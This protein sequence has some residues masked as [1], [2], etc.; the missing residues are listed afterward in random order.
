LPVATSS[1]MTT[2]DAEMHIAG[3]VRDRGWVGFRWSTLADRASQ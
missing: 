3:T 1:S 2:W